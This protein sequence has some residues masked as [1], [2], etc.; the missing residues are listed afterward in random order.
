ML[1]RKFKRII[2]LLEIV[3]KGHIFNYFWRSRDIRQNVR[4]ALIKSNI[5]ES[6]LKE[7]LPSDNLLHEENVTD[8]K[9]KN[10]KI[11]S[12]WFQGEQFAPDLVKA[13]F[14]SIRKH[15]KQE[16]VVLDENTIYNYITLPPSIIKKYKTGKISRAHFAD[17]CRV[18]LLYEHGGFWLD[19]TCFVTSP[20]PDSI[21]NQDFFMYLAGN[22]CP[23]SFIQNCFIRAKKGAFLLKAWRNMIIDYW[24]HEN[25][26]INYFMHQLLFKSLISNNFLARQYFDKMLHIDQDPTHVLYYQYLDKCYNHNEFKE[27]TKDSFFQKC[28]H[29]ADN[30]PKPGSYLEYILNS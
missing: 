9:C 16:L 3:V 14:K 4:S 13:C 7:Y 1:L 12:I 22:I 27:I 24:I 17:I 23:A 26:S 5:L 6:Y 20:I 29:H 28:C 21:E 30:I 10:E 2:V 15:C 8:S 19:A 18:E 25:R 11:F